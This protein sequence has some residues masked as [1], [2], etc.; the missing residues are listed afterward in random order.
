MGSLSLPKEWSRFLDYPEKEAWW[1]ELDDWYAGQCLDQTQSQPICPPRSLVFNALEN[2]LPEQVLVVI[3]GQDP[4]H[5]RGQAHGLSFSVPPGV[6][7][8]PSLVNIQKELRRSFPK[9]FQKVAPSDLSGWAKQG[10]LLLNTVLSVRE[11]R[12]FSHKNKGWE[13]LTGR[14]IKRLGEENKGIVFMLWG[15]PARAHKDKI[16][17]PSHL[18]LEAPHPSP[19][20]AHRG[21]LG[22]DHFQKANTHFLT[23]GAKAV[24]W[25]TCEGL[26]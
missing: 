14:I 24:D 10:V 26:F 19:L 9:Q 6:P 13:I 22:C 11:G 4:Y 23:V 17:H 25:F 12:P 16:I 21:F 20:S 5:R 3:L 15:N 2:T 8:P 18:I 1:L 7:A